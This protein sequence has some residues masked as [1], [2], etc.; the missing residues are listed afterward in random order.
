MIST[1]E[2][3]TIDPK[4]FLIKHCSLPAL[5]EI[6]NQIQEI[7]YSK[8]VSVDKLAKLISKDAA[9]VAQILKIVNSAYYS[10]SIDISEVRHAVAYL[11]MNEIHRIVLSLSVINT[12]S[13]EEKSDFD[14]IWFHSLLTA[15]GTKYI[16]QKYEPKINVNELW[17]AALLHDIGKFIY[18]KFFPDHYKMLRKLYN[19]RL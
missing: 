6:L 7:M 16:A 17:S 11:G 5:P 13:I 4:T 12:F 8:D 3:F 14:A 19:V 18:L 15:L 9:L 2:P 1:L 10:L